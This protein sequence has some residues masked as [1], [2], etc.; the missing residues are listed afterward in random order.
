MSRRNLATGLDRDIAQMANREIQEGMAHGITNDMIYGGILAGQT[1]LQGLR[2]TSL[3]QNCL[4]GTRRVTWEGDVFKYAYPSTI[5]ITGGGNLCRPGMGAKNY[6]IPG[7]L[8][9]TGGNLVERSAGDKTVTITLDAT[10]GLA[11]WFGTAYNMVGAKAVFA[12]LN[13]P[14][15][16]TII[17]HDTGDDGETI[18]FTLDGV[19]QATIAAASQLEITPNAYTCLMSGGDEWSSVMGVP[20]AP[21]PTLYNG[22]IQ[23]WG[24]LWVTPS[25][26][27]V[28]GGINDRTVVF[29]NDGSIHQ[30]TDHTWG[31]TD[32]HQY[33]GFISHRTGAGDWANPPFIMLQISP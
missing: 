15:M 10:S 7:F 11:T 21:M 9:V 25:V 5:S 1:A 14:Q 26:V 3:T 19:V 23:T 20:N 29:H 4:Y 8:N 32:G 28:G 24:I 27:G 6:H 30:S 17:A 12:G 13:P 33:A 31:G 16:F 18:E 22:W 2:S